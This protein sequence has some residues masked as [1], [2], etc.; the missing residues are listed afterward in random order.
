MEKKQIRLIALDLDG[1][2]LDSQKRL[3]R[4]NYEALAR[5]AERG[6]EIVPTTGRFYGGMP[7]EI[8]ALP[9]L[10]Y[11]IGINGA[12]VRELASGEALYQADIPWRDTLALMEYLDGKQCYYDCYA[13]NSGFM[14]EEM[15]ENIETHLKDPIYRGMIVRTRRPV[16]ELK[17]Y[18]REREMNVQKVQAYPGEP[19]LR[20]ALLQ[21]L[22]KAFPALLA[23]SSIAENIE[24][25]AAAANKGD[26]LLTLAAHLGLERSQL[27]AFGD[28]LNDV[29]MLRE[30]GVGVAMDNASD[31]IKACADVV[32]ASCDEDGVAQYLEQYVL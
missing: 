13:G 17:T 29:T 28:G 1:T 23:T 19:A 10:H 12:E 7:E 31:E 24:I 30:A 32:T 5:A 15:F 3:S 14:T 21:E 8:R 18:I 9:F 6:I 25:N 27:A 11:V 20:L 26:A 16:P 22:P 4:R 2:L